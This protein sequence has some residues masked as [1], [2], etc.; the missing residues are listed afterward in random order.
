MMPFITPVSVILGVVFAGWLESFQYLVPWIF[1]FMTFAGSL[2]SNFT[3]VRH[4]IKHPVPLLICLVLLHL[5]MPIISLGVGNVFFSDDPYLI[6]GLILAFI[7]PTGITSLIW[8]S[9]YRGNVVLTLSIILLD[10]L[11]S[12]LLVPLI[13]QAFVGNSIQMDGWEIMTGLFWMVVIPSLLGMS[14]NQFTKGRVKVTVEPKLAPFAK[15]AIIGVISINSSGV[16]S[17]FRNI[18]LELILVALVVFIIA[19]SGYFLGWLT[20]SVLKQSRANIISLTFNSGMRNISAGAV[21][22][23]TYFPDAAALPVIVGM[24]FQQVI[25]STTGGL[26]DR[27]Y[28]NKGEGSVI[29]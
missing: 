8:V 24:L 17:Y 12:P 13:L 2:G 22:A 7:I 23:I 26:L 6:T 18:S 29:V 1:A 11:L 16:A 10:T 21:I 3:D 20:A 9:I 15:L 14:L 27:M 5:I 19:V 25:A 4:V 28:R